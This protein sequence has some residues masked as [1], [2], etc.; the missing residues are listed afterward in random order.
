M[1]A[2]Q[3]TDA[4]CTRA[5]LRLGA[6][7]ALTVGKKVYFLRGHQIELEGVAGEMVVVRGTLGARDT[8]Y[9]DEVVPLV[10]QAVWSHKN[11]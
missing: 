4:E 2:K 9:V 8:I 7:Y 11:D 3:E 5:R 6:A 1:K 10:T